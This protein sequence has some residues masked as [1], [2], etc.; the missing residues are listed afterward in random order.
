MSAIRSH[1]NRRRSFTNPVVMKN[2]ALMPCRFEDRQRVVV[3]VSIP[4]VEGHEHAVGRKR[5]PGAMSRQEL[6]KTDGT[7]M[8]PEIDQLRVE[9]LWRRIDHVWI[10]VELR[11]SATR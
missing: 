8:P 4:V 10:Q 6:G 9:F 2:S 7:E 11:G 5:P 1:Q 3:V